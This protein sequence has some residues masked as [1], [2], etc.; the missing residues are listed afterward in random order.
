MKRL[1]K[2]KNAS[3]IPEMGKYVDSGIRI[4]IQTICNSHFL[5][6]HKCPP[7]HLQKTSPYFWRNLRHYSCYCCCKTSRKDAGLANLMLSCYNTS[8]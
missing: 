8:I 2:W 3:I 1:Q 4:G 7:V 5:T 6:Q